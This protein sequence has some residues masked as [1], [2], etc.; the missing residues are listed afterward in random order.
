M[1]AA[2]RA[3]ARSIS[4]DEIVTI[5]YH[6]EASEELQL[7][8]DD[9]VVNTAYGLTE[10]WGTTDD[11]NEWRVHIRDKFEGREGGFP[12]HDEDS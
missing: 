2:E 7:T 1:S 11:G 8:C 4:H 9:W 10:Y 5:D 6:A 3:I 12:G